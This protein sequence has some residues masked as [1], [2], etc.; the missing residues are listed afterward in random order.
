[1]EKIARLA[2]KHN[3]LSNW[4]IH[5]V[6]FVTYLEPALNSVK[7]PFTRSFLSNLSLMFI[8][9]NINKLNSYKKIPHQVLSQER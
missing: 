3:I 5:L 8:K 4:Q 6:F 1:M 2:Y 9:S 7:D